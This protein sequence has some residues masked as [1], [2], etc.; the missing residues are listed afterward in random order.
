MITV[1]LVRSGTH[2][3]T[4]KIN[5]RNKGIFV[6][7]F[8]DIEALVCYMRSNHCGVYFAPGDTGLSLEQLRLF[9]IKYRAMIHKNYPALDRKIQREVDRLRAIHRY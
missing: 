5:T 2:S 4:Y 9:R 6:K 8:K 1:R 3:K 7:K